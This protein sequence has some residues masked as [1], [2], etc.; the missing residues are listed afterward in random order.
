MILT[1]DAILSVPD[2]K[3]ERI[4]VPEW[5]GEVIVRSLTGGERTAYEAAVSRMDDKGN[6]RVNRGIV[7]ARL[8]VL[9]VVDETGQR[10]FRDDDAAAL[11]A[12]NAAAIERIFDVARRLS[13]MTP[14]DVEELEKNCATEA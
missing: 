6:V 2:L 14:Q 9:S 3:T 7:R 12:K 8:V 11:N 4:R 5:G 13:G 1:R 10:V